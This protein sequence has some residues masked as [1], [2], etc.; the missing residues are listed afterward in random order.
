MK[1]LFPS[2][3]EDARLGDVVAKFPRTIAPLLDYHDRLLRDPG[4]LSPGQKELIA[5]YVSGLN[6]CAFC[7]GAHTTM[8]RAHGID[9]DVIDALMADPDTA[10]VEPAMRPLLAYVSKLTRSP[11]M[12]TEADADAVY[13]AGWSEDAL[14]EAIQT[15]GL[16][17]LMNRILEG[18][19]ITE[20]YADP[21]TVP[22]ERLEELRSPHFY[23]EFG[24]ANGVSS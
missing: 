11:A 14:F 1:R 10:P 17:S 3:P 18:T 8:A 4:A 7:H 13:A 2:L 12:M 20:Y 15:C 6:A 21:R 22:E 16:N 24:R 5:A 23:T 9:P 19:G